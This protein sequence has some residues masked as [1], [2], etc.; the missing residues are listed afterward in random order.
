MLKL[1]S[2]V[3]AQES[4][5]NFWKLLPC[6]IKET[7]VDLMGKNPSGSTDIKLLDTRVTFNWKYLDKGTSASLYLV[8]VPEKRVKFALKICKSGITVSAADHLLNHSIPSVVSLHSV[9]RLSVKE[10]ETSVIA[11]DLMDSSWSDFLESQGSTTDLRKGIESVVQLVEALDGLI[12]SGFIHDNI[13]PSNIMFDFEGK[14]AFVDIDN[15]IS[16]NDDYAEYKKEGALSACNSLIGD[17]LRVND[18][19][20]D[21]LLYKFYMK[22]FVEPDSIEDFLTKLKL[23]MTTDF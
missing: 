7:L 6:S 9:D 11:M 2:L 5:N 13:G 17:I 20:E 15:L 4:E 1:L 16:T 3:S 19:S 18:I 21:T 22:Q 14:V 12:K 8:E 10:K 23:I